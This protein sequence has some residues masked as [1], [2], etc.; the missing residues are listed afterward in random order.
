MAKSN[1]KITYYQ[2]E[3]FSTLCEMLDKSAA[4]AG[5]TAAFRYKED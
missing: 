3:K 4:A 1:G 5:N 2:V